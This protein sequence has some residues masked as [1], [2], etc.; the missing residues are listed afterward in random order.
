MVTDTRTGSVVAPACSGCAA[1]SLGGG[2]IWSPDGSSLAWGQDG[3]VVV[4]RAGDWSGAIVAD[5]SPVSWSPDGSMIAYTRT[6]SDFL[7]STVYARATA[8]GDETTIV[9]V[10]D[11]RGLSDEMA[12]SADG[13]QV[14]VPLQAAES[15]DV[16]GLDPATGALRKF[17]VGAPS[18][19]PVMLSPDGTAI[20]DRGPNL[21]SA[22]DGSSS[23]SAGGGEMT[24]W[25]RDGQRVLVAGDG[26]NAVDLVTGAKTHLLDGNVQDAAWSPDEREIA[27]V[28]DQRLGVLEVA[29]GKT[30]DI[31]PASIKV[32]SQA[33][34]GDGFVA[35]SPDGA[36]ILVSDGFGQVDGH[37]YQVDADGEHLTN[38]TDTPTNARY[39]TFS[40]DGKYVAYVN[41]RGPGVEFI[42]L[43]TGKATSIRS[44]D[45]GQL[46]WTAGD[47]LLAD[48]P[49]GIALVKV[50]GS[51]RLLVEDTGGC[52]VR[53]IGW[54]GTEI[55]FSNYCSHMGL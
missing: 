13:K 21:V 49:L 14:V 45:A 11:N 53:L 25:S 44:I 15:N 38:L 48:T 37:L 41:L 6:A 42:D 18:S 8:G 55:A 5:G 31:A 20:F 4:A 17:A 51:S 36:H 52:V 26:L 29:S 7:S 16:Y 2:G 39:M 19:V 54:T 12:W 43:S 32:Y 46:A 50:D 47:E 22:L 27:F 28:R 33:V 9:K 23:H 40:A 1:E 24:D 35:W 10:T 3:H 30:I 34:V